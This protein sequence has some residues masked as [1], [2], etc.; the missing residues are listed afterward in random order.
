MK[1]PP[2]TAGFLLIISLFL[3]T[4][5]AQEVDLS[6]LQG[7]AVS[8]LNI[9]I[10][11]HPGRV[12]KS[13]FTIVTQKS[14]KPFR[15]SFNVMDLTQTEGGT[16]NPVEVGMGTRSAAHWITINAAELIKPQTR[17][18]IPFTITVPPYAEGAYFAY[19]VIQ[20]IPEEVKGKMV[21]DVR[22]A[23]AIEVAVKTRSRS[24]LHVDVKEFHIEPGA[25]GGGDDAVLRLVNTGNWEAY[26]SGDVLLYGSNT[27]FPIHGTIPHTRTGELI[28]IY[29]GMEIVL[30]C[31]LG[32]NLLDD[33]YR[34]VARLLIN[35]KWQ[36]KIE[37]DVQGSKTTTGNASIGKL[38]KKSE[39]DLDLQIEP[40]LVEITIP[41]GA[42]RIVPIKM[43]NRDARKAHI[44]LSVSDVRIEKNGMLTFTEGISQ[45]S[46]WIDVTPERMV[47]GA[48]QTSTARSKVTV[49]RERPEDSPLV[50]AVRLEASTQSTDKN[51]ESG[52]EF[53]V[54]IVAVDPKAP[55]AKLI[56]EK[57][58]LLRSA[59]DKNPVTALVHVKNAGGRVADL[60]GN[61]ELKRLNGET[62]VRKEIGTLHK[63]IILPGYEREFRLPLGPLDE[64]DFCVFAQITER[65]DPGS[66]TRAEK[67]FK[68]MTKMP[69]GL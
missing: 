25:T 5:S 26:V 55:P 13:N 34:A 65:G 33:R 41:P 64:G 32:Q 27:T 53:G 3:N 14:P 45:Q 63:E 1:I 42:S 39:Y 18:R 20:F 69:T 57:P 48:R 52:N 54:L 12:Q 60:L 6:E 8:P 47:I 44:A 49:P 21:T 11:S 7:F 35:D 46:G 2:F 23:A 62:I 58:K 51:W 59:A 31:P 66:K 43:H 37:F 28:K 30:E 68:S 19:I 56:M 24:P 29:P 15:F 38:L 22:P 16:K 17:Q 40:E 50:Q 36:S 4:L 9:E 67:I 10:D 61:I